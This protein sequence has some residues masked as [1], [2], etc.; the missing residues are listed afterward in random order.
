MGGFLVNVFVRS[1]DQTAV[2]E[3]AKQ[4]LGPSYA[5]GRGFSVSSGP[6]FFVSPAVD[7]WVGLHDARMQNQDESLCEAVAAKLSAMLKSTAIT[8]L[9]HDGDFLCYWLAHQGAIVDTYNSMPDYFGG[10]GDFEISDDEDSVETDEDDAMPGEA[11]EAQG[12]EGGNAQIL[13]ELCGRPE[14]A[15][16]V[17]EILGKPD[18]D[19]YALLASL[20]KA[21]GIPDP[22]VDYDLLTYVPHRLPSGEIIGFQPKIAHRDRYTAVT[23]EDW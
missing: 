14:Q 16:A 13:T 21:L 2:V 19:G 1:D 20:G 4:V 15:D 10:D 23:Q 3:A 11:V 8:F 22:T 9:V 18:H 7:G 6:A 5:R 17:A 12:P